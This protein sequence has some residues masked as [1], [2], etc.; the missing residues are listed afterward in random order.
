MKLDRNAAE[1]IEENLDRNA[2]ATSSLSSP[3]RPSRLKLDGNEA[4]GTGAEALALKLDRNA[5]AFSSYRPCPSR[6]K[7]VRDAAPFSSL[8]LARP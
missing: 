2:A 7:L 8:K 1:E 4:A 6:L 5:A 3:P